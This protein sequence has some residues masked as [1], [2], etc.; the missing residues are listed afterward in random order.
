MSATKKTFVCIFSAVPDN[1][2]KSFHLNAKDEP[3][4]AFEVGNFSL[5]VRRRS[6]GVALFDTH[7][8][9]LI[10][11]NQF[12]QITTTLPGEKVFGLG[13]HRTGENSCSGGARVATERDLYS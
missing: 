9:P 4:F 11:A 12:L 3:D 13:E 7:L 10:F 8:A 6:D 1:G 5:I 2:E